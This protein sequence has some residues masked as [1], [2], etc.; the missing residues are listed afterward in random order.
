MFG[1][2][3]LPYRVGPSFESLLTGAAEKARLDARIC[4][5]Y[6]P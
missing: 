4:F 1:Y 3:H 5:N 6:T 2:P